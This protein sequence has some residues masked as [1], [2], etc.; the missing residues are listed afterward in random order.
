LQREAKQ[1][2]EVRIGILYM[3]KKAVGAGRKALENKV[4]VIKI[5]KNS[6]EWRQIILKIAQTL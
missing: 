1:K 3:G 6:Q 4:P 5:V 2:A